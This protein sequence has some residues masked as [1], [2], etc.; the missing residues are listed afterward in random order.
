ME[1]ES[2]LDRAAQQVHDALIDFKELLVD[3]QTPA[4]VGKIGV[5]ALV[6]KAEFER[7]ADHSVT[8]GAYLVERL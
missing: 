3:A 2:P 1:S 6:F 4:E 5:L 8:R 7:I